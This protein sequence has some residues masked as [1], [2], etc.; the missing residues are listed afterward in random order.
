MW[1]SIPSPALF[2]PLSVSLA[3]LS[4]DQSREAAS[5][6]SLPPPLFLP[7]VTSRLVSRGDVGVSSFYSLLANSYSC[8]HP[9]IFFDTKIDLDN[10]SRIAFIEYLLIHFKVLILSLSP[11]SSLLFSIS[12]LPPPALFHSLPLPPYPS[13]SFPVPLH[14]PALLCPSLSPSPSSLSP[15]LSSIIHRLIYL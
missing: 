3:L 5:I 1:C 6:F 2:H 9:D 14:L 10:N 8:P 15:S 11:F 12:T 7:A 4:D 13:L